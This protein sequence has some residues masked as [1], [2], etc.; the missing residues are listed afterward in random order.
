MIKKKRGQVQRANSRGA[1]AEVAHRCARTFR[2][3]ARHAARFAPTS[4]HRVAAACAVLR[5]QRGV[6]GCAS[7]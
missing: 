3:T 2:A 7:A 6:V 1:G 5:A 4:E